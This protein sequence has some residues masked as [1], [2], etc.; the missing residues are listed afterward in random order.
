[1]NVEQFQEYGHRAFR[2]LVEEYGFHEAPRPAGKLVNDYMVCFSNGVTWVGVEGINWGFGVDVK[3]AS[4]DV[5][6]MR[7]PTYSLQDLLDLRSPG[8]PLPTAKPTDTLEIQKTQMDW[9]AAALRIHAKD[10]LRGDFAVFPQLA[11]AIT[12]R[13]GQPNG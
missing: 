12:N 3:L 7:Y 9:Y 2:F 5:A 6:H 10:V 8:F 13:G 1:M 4:H 11:E